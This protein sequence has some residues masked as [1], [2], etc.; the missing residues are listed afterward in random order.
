MRGMK[1]IGALAIVVVALLAPSLYRGGR[2][3]AQTTGRDA[4][5]P[6]TV[7]PAVAVVPDDEFLRWP[8]APADQIYSAIDGVRI[9]GYVKELTAISRRYRDAGHQYWGRL[10]GLESDRW[11]AEWLAQKFRDI[12][13]TN[14]RIQSIDLPPQWVPTSWDVTAVS[15]TETA[16]L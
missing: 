7:R 6:K 11:T 8:V 13:A 2:P 9:K 5:A 1:L 16:T 15:G 14:V 12:G 3:A 10:I 4:A